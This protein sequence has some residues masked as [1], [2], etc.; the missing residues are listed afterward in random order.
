MLSV[1]ATTTGW[2][3]TGSVMLVART[4]SPAAAITAASAV[5]PSSQGC[6]QKRWSFADTVA[7][8]RSRASRTYAVSSVRLDK[9]SPKS[10]NGRC[11]PSLML[12]PHPGTVP[13][14]VRLVPA[15]LTLVQPP[16]ISFT[17]ARVSASAGDLSSR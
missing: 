12:L 15:E 7:N 8:P 4:M 3:T 13:G 10:A 1:L 6:R 11:T 16:N 2:R 17:I 5:G 14:R 9:P